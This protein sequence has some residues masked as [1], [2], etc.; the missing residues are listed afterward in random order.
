MKTLPKAVVI[1]R[2]KGRIRIR[3]AGVDTDRN[4]YF[5]ELSNALNKR[6]N[7][8]TIHVNP[9]TGS[10]LL[11][12]PAIDL[13]AVVRCGRSKKLFRMKT[14][15]EPGPG[16]AATIAQKQVRRIDAGIRTL[17]SGSLDISGSLFIILIL[18][19]LREI[20]R[21]NLSTPSWFTALW[22]A[23]TIYNRNF[24]GACDD[25]FRIHSHDDG[26]ACSA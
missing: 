8:R 1:H 6:F 20:F 2:M 26:D 14:N 11:K 3:I 22:F 17:T 23:S 19:A 5:T 10:V 13:D 25:N 7:Y 21:G 4:R 15:E 18:H 24:F 9:V 16:N 12:E